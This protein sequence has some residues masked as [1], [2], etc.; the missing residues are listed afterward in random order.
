MSS[1]RSRDCEGQGYIKSKVQN[2]GLKGGIQNC[3]CTTIHHDISQVFLCV[4]IQS[5]LSR[6]YSRKFYLLA[7]ICIE[8][9]ANLEK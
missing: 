7:D 2:K 9:Y 8:G 3:S 5:L 1:L 6:T 4:N